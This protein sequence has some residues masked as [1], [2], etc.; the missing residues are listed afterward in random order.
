MRA[1]QVMRVCV[2]TSQG[3]CIQAARRLRKRDRQFTRIQSIEGGRE[4]DKLYYIAH[5]SLPDSLL[6]WQ[7]IH[8]SKR[9]LRVAP[10][11]MIYFSLS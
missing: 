5:E 11:D 10:E 8:I 7:R 3:S 6:Y 2:Y 4:E 9:S 1:S